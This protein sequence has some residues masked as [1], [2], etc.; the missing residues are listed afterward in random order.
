MNEEQMLEKKVWAVVGANQNPEKYGNRIYKKLKSRGYEVYPV[1][2]GYE[3]VEGDKCYRDLSSL[4]QKPEVIDM[5]VSPKR[6]KTVIEEAAKLGIKN[7]WLQPGTYDDELL[8]RINEL[9]LDA[10]MACVL[11][12]LR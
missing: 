5:V 9:E 4:P 10:V 2:P 11:V 12:A 3:T 7:I 8:K 1:N 6:G